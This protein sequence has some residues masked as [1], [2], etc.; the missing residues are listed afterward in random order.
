MEDQRS[1]GCCEV[2]MK[3]VEEADRWII[4][5][6]AMEGRDAGLPGHGKFHVHHFPIRLQSVPVPASCPALCRSECS[7]MPKPATGVHILLQH[8]K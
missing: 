3:K 8:S 5:S 6:E 7:R 2:E 1:S 4:R